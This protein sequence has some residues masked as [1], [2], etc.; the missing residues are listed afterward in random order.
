MVFI[1]SHDEDLVSVSSRVVIIEKGEKIFDSFVEEVLEKRFVEI[2]TEN[3]REI[4]PS[5]KLS[6]FKN[7]R[8]VRVVGIRESLLVS[9]EKRR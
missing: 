7:Y 6:E 9:S 5:S 8:I 4:V 1:A 3:E 2:E